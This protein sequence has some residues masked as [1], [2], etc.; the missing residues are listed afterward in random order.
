M[1]KLIR[2]GLPCEKCDSSDAAAEYD[3]GMYCF[4]CEQSYQSEKITEEL[5]FEKGVMEIIEK[6]DWLKWP[7][8]RT[9]Y[10]GDR[11]RKILRSTME[12]Y[13]VKATTN[14][15]AF[16]FYKDNH[17]VGLKLRNRNEKTFTSQGKTSDLFGLHKFPGSYRKVIIT[18]G[19][20][21]ALAVAQSIYKQYQRYYPVLSIG[22][23][24]NT[25]LLLE[26]RSWLRQQEEVVLWFDND[27]QGA[28]ATKKAIKI[29]GQDKAR[30]VT[31]SEKDANDL[32][33]KEGPR[34]VRD[35]IWSANMWT[36]ASILQGKDSWK[37][38]KEYREME[39]V[40]WPPFL[41]K[42]NNMTHGRAKRTITMI[43]A[44][45]GI[46]KS[47]LLKEDAL[48]L[49]ATTPVEEKVGVMFF[50]E[51]PG[52]TVSSL[53]SLKLNKRIGLPGV[54]ITEEE[55]KEAWED[56]F[57]DNRIMLLNHQG[58]VNDK[59]SI[60]DKIEYMCL[61]GCN[62]ILFDHI[63]I[64]VSESAM[65]TNNA[66]D[67]LMSDLLKIVKKYPVW[68][69][70]VSHLRKTPASS[71]DGKNKSKSFEE[72]GH[73][74]EDDLKGS[75]SLKQISFQTIAISRNKV[76]DSEEEKHTS[77]LFLLKDRCTGSSGY[78]GSFKYDVKTG[79]LEDASTDIDNDDID[80]DDLGFDLYSEDIEEGVE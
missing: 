53:I 46:G 22:S 68:I 59:D 44:G 73:I 64:A 43:G 66:I 56:I 70:V 37:H 33:I 77:K 50:E 24:S 61:A 10:E 35:A 2:S 78:A 47:T 69:G 31:T 20:F 30:M 57:S 34:A 16:P 40:P 29:I 62:Y 11:D 55:E 23:V 52:E 45:T 19:E 27:E 79:R 75:G 12:F 25:N 58:S 74:S 14:E 80:I 72:G 21:D 17:L 48:H 32:L 60:V 65:D 9:G 3:N 7:Y 18:E 4:S 15:Y 38:Y 28:K 13:G 36:P 5:E 1:S 42:L 71:G 8:N 54:E 26:N 76:A 49:L 6:E 63:T 41:S 51:D 67:K 39:F